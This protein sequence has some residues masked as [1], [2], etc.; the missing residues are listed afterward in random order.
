MQRRDFH[1]MLIA[2][3]ALAL[4]PGLRAGE[5]FAQTAMNELTSTLTPEPSVLNPAIATSNA[6]TLVAGKMYEGLVQ[7]DFDLTPQPMLAESWEQSEDGLTYTFKLVQNATW[8]DG[9][10]FTSADVVFSCDVMLR[11]THPR[12]R[13]L[14]DQCESITAPDD[15]TVEFKLKAPFGPFLMAMDTQNVPIMPRHIYEGKDYRATELNE[16]PIGTGPF[17][18]VEWVRGAYIH[19]AKNEN[20]RVEGQ[21]YLEAIY[22]RIIPD[23]SSRAVALETGEVQLVAW[24]D[25]EKFDVNR[26]AELPGIE[27]TKKGYEYFSPLMWY[28]ANL[29]REPFNDLRFRKAMM[30]LIDKD[31]MVERIL[32]GHGRAA[33]GPISEATRFHDP[34][35]PTYDFDP[36]KAKA[37][38]DEIGLTP[39]ADGVRLRFTFQ[40]VPFGELQ[41]RFA[42]YFRQAMSEA[43]IV[44]TL[45]SNDVAGW[46][47][48]ISNW[49]YD[50]TGNILFQY[51]DPAL[52]VSRTYVSSN[53]RKGV[54]FSNTQGY[55]NPEVDRLFAEAASAVGDEARQAKYSE[56]Q[57]LLVEE[58]PVLWVMEQH[59]PTLY[60][61][62]LT[63]LITGATGV[64][65]SFATAKYT[66]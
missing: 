15:Y 9:E 8:H 65:A 53:I 14:F 61:D 29:R 7:L 19:L 17:K 32:Y 58:L 22:Y 57:R 27:M 1:K 31:L 43:G 34:D 20:Y 2:G 40:V 39:D 47:K 41:T 36:E 48:K 63:D 25:V 54:M 52:G 4:T 60:D 44:V 56:V 66:S 59:F 30:H 23:G 51:G 50:M 35:L 28:E 38:L 26:L 18:F 13:M 55:E 16:M 62:R 10:P 12:A 45:E 33:T 24:S 64:N 37:L 42:E 46:S 11:E 5:V 6:T 49:D 3:G 21:P